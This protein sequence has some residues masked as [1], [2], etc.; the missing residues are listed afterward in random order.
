MG[1]EGVSL[2]VEVCPLM[3]TVDTRLAYCYLDATANVKE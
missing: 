2:L 1:K 3:F